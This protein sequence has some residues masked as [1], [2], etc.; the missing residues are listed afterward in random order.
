MKKQKIIPHLW[1]DKEAK[2][3][4]GFY[5]SVFGGDSRVI[6][7]QTITDTPSGD[8]EIVSFRFLG[9]ELMS[10][11]AG[12]FF[13]FNPSVSFIVNFDPSQDPDAR[14]NLDSLWG[15]LS[16]GGMPHFSGKW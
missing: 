2:E 4:A 11:S 6:S 12:P 8:S 10:I 7:S 16:V 5:V 1:F 13:K 3:A 9:Q 15:K 14:K